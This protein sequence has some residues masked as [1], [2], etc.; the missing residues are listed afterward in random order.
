MES[1][2]SYITPVYQHAKAMHADL[3]REQLKAN[4]I[5]QDLLRALKA[6]YDAQQRTSHLGK[7]FTRMAHGFWKG[8]EHDLKHASSISLELCNM[9]NEKA[10]LLEEFVKEIEQDVLLKAGVV[11][12]A[13]L[14]PQA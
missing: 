9:L 14:N 8:Q 7:G 4:D 11:D 12:P 6:L 5:A 3:I 1:K 2:V 13:V 10:T